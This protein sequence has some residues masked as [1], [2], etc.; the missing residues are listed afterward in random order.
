M[1]R[2]IRVVKVIRVVRVIRV[3]WGKSLSC[4]IFKNTSSNVVTW[5]RVIRV[6]G[7]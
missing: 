6:I 5:I 4:A 7:Y 3:T 1:I 2:V